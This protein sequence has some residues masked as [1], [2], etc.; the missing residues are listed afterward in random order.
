[1]FGHRIRGRDYWQDDDWAQQR[2]L[3]GKVSNFGVS[4]YTGF[5]ELVGEEVGESWVEDNRLCDRWSLVGGDITKCVLIFRD[6]DSGPN[7]YYMV[8]DTGPHP[9]SVVN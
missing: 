9:F 7:N 1:M 5:L 2:S 4:A 8:T 6:P 3:E